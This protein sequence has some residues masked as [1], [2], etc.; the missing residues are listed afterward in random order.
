MREMRVV[1]GGGARRVEEVGLSGWTGAGDGRADMTML[2]RVRL[3]TGILE[4]FGARSLIPGD[5][6]GGCTSTV[7]GGSTG[8]SD[9]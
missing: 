2:E 3:G 4:G 8:G 9:A 6:D 5:S 7:G 1:C